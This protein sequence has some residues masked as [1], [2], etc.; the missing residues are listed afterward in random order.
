M[1]VTIIGGE[2]LLGRDLRER[3]SQRKLGFDPQLI[4]AEEQI[5]IIGEASEEP[6]VL[7]AMTPALLAGSDII[8]CTGSRASTLKAFEIAGRSETVF[9]DL[10][11]ALEDE[12]AA[13]L[14]SPATEGEDFPSAG[15]SV[16]VVAHSAAVALT[17][18]LSEVAT[19]SPIQHAVITILEPASERGNAGIMELQQQTTSLLSFRPLEKRVF[20]A[21]VAFNLLPRLGEDAPEPL[22]Q[23]EDRI[24]RH[25]ATLLSGIAGVPGL[26][27]VRLA[28]APVFHGYSF[29]AWVQFQSK[30][31]IV[32]LLD[33]L[34]SAGFD[35]RGPG[36]EPPNNVEVAGDSGVTVGVVEA[37]RNQPNALWLWAACDNFRLTVDNALEC[38][39]PYLGGAK[40]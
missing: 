30:P 16:H 22:E 12:P 37:D 4:A 34:Q 2:T 14:R 27:S 39:M 5:S 23:T 38:A 21:Q 32:T 20:D 11:G 28:Q 18:L 31:D 40:R 3:L 36:A 9:I 17:I 29:S 25:L 8:F 35:V 6:V 10:T 13:R 19:V 24:E 15:T 1:N 33:H 7:A 26:P